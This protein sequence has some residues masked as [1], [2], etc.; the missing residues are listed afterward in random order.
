MSDPTAIPPD[1]I[2]PT[3]FPVADYLSEDWQFETT[4]W[5]EAPAFVSDNLDTE[6]VARRNANHAV[7]RQIGTA[8][9]W[10][11]YLTL[12]YYAFDDAV[13]FDREWSKWTTDPT[14][15]HR[16]I[17]YNYLYQVDRDIQISH[18][19]DIW[20]NK[21]SHPYLL[22][23][24]PASTDINTTNYTW[25]KW[26]AW[27]NRKVVPMDIDDSADWSLVKPRGRSRN[28]S[29]PI[30]PPSKF[31]AKPSPAS[32]KNAIAKVRA[33][34]SVPGFNL[35]P[36]DPYHQKNSVANDSNRSTASTSDTTHFDT[37]ITNNLPTSSTTPAIS[38]ITDWNSE[39]S[40]QNTAN[41]STTILNEDENRPPA[42]THLPTND[43][44]HRV[45]IKWSVEKSDEDTL[46]TMEN[47]T[48][49]MNQ[50]IL[51]ILTHIF[52]DNDGHFYR[53]ESE[54]LEQASQISALTQQ[55]VRDFVTPKVTIIHSRQLFIFGARF[56]FNTNP[57]KWKNSTKQSVLKTAN[58]QVQVSNSISTSGNLAIAGYILLKAPN[59]THRHRYVQH[60]IRQL[61]ENTP[62]FDVVR[63]VKTPM[64]Q[65]M[66]HLAI[67]C[68]ENHVAPLCQALSNHLTGRNK[69]LFIP[70]YVLSAM[71]DTQI[72]QHFEAHTN[73]VR[74][75][76]ALP[77]APMVSHIDQPRREYNSDGTITVRSAREWAS[78]LKLSNSKASALCDIENGTSDRKTSLLVPKHYLKE[79]TAQLREYKMRLSPP[80]H[81]QARYKDSIP[82]LPNTIHIPTNIKSNL[83]YMDE[84]SAETI[85]RQAPAAVRDKNSSHGSMQNTS[86]V[87]NKRHAPR[88]PNFGA[89]DTVEDQSNKP[90]QSTAS[91]TKSGHDSGSWKASD[92]STP[93]PATSSIGITDDGDRSNASTPLTRGS[94][95][96]AT[97]ARFRDIDAMIKKQ[98]RTID[99]HA[100]QA[101]DRLSS[102]EHHFQRFDALNSKID[103]VGDQVRQ[104]SKENHDMI[105]TM[106][107]EF[108]KRNTHMEAQNQSYRDHCDNKLGTFGEALVASL[109]DISLLRQEFTKLSHYLMRDLESRPSPVVE[110]K[111]RKQRTLRNP[112]DDF[113]AG[114][115]IPDESLNDTSMIEEQDDEDDDNSA[116]SNP[117]VARKLDTA[118]QDISSPPRDAVDLPLP[119]SPTQAPL[120]ASPSPTQVRSSPT[121]SASLDPRNTKN[122]GLAEANDL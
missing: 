52:D 57:V 1:P 105:R 41:S 26:E 94:S 17:F 121:Q 29:P 59:A 87:I 68:G 82:G 117:G 35:P 62:Y 101:A 37:T 18:K 83:S 74:S 53:W 80:S 47:N 43:G 30:N 60:L 109:E 69:A 67:Q 112:F 65:I 15:I 86:N 7:Y 73:W 119:L 118:F 66:P 98:Q 45:I 9:T 56:C 100:K 21:I 115:E 75:L 4:V 49:R 22:Q 54:D 55:N 81:R 113:M 99:H 63:L 84:L 97:Q 116:S 28:K 11:R 120:P 39:T 107:Y 79:A 33:S 78:S 14:T 46:T 58:L 89:P 72:T 61:P 6:I 16:I 122:T 5:H 32:T 12:G 19:L 13:L 24:D 27:K 51:K 3:S 50:A 104:A 23:Y 110:P 85:W 25:P 77:L 92:D 42:I 76:T 108:D 20:A 36:D 70:R 90:S 102:I 93:A 114:V 64:D 38:N 71:P 34:S 95:I 91:R 8:T 48:L 88:Y 103:Q 111:R 40:D 96:T 106:C 31:S 44:T 2:P 10:L